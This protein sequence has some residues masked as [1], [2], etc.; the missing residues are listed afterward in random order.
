MVKSRKKIKKIMYNLSMNPS[1]SF[2]VIPN[3]NTINQ[4]PD[5][6][7]DIDIENSVKKAI[8]MLIRTKSK[9][10]DKLLHSTKYAANTYVLCDMFIIRMDPIEWL[11]KRA[12][13][14][15]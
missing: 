14:D 7:K 2:T 4:V 9:N 8:A 13:F 5:L 15:T 11:S 10:S 3:E 6:L 1:N 12:T